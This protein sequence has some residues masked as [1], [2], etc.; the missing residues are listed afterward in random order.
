MHYTT[1]M[2]G[3]LTQMKQGVQYKRMPTAVKVLAIIAMAPWVAT[4]EIF[5]FIYR[6]CLFVYKALAAPASHLHQWMKEQKDE[7]KHATQAVLYAVCLPFIFFLQIVLSLFSIVFYLVWFVY[8]LNGY[9][10]SFGGIKWQPSIADASYENADV[11][12]DYKPG[13]VGTTVYVSMTF[14]FLVLAL[15]FGL[16][17]TV[18]PF[19]ETLA[20]V[21]VF[22]GAYAVMVW[23]V[24]P[25]M[26]RKVKVQAAPAVEAEADV[27]EVEAG[28]PEAEETVEATEEIAE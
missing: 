23:I 18:A 5:G 15:L 27:A 6:I 10:L 1:L 12:G 4:F 8:M 22:G 24:N 20:L 28:E 11:S 13:F 14:G 9:I 2:K 19:V 7:I 25:I 3:L 26:F 21:L 17:F 16:I